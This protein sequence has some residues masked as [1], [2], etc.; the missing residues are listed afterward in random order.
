MS[1][2]P[3]T[4]DEPELLTAAAIEEKKK[5]RKHFGRFDIFFYLICTL[6]G[7][8][9]IGAAASKGAQGFTWLA[10]LGLF[11]FIP[12]GLLTA[13]LGSTFTDEGGPYTW[14]RMAFGRLVG[15][16]VSVL[17][18]LSNP[19][20]VGGTLCVTAVAAI[21]TFFFPAHAPMKEPVKYGISLFFIWGSVLAAVL[22]F[23]V[24]KWV[25]TVGAWARCGLLVFFT[26]SV[27]LY[28]VKN[29]VH[30][31]S[32]RDFRPTYDHFIALTPILLFNYFGFEL[33]S[34]AGDEMKNP[35]RDVPYTVARAAG[36]TLLLY[37]LPVLAVL[38]V[39]PAGQV[40]SL[41]GFL[42]AI[43]AVFTVYGGH[44]DAQGHA[45]LTGA[46]F[47]LGQAGAAAVVLALASSGTTWLMG[48]DRALAV[49]AYDGAGPRLLGRFSERWGTPVNANIL[50][51]ILSTIVMVLAFKLTHGDANKYFSAVLGLAISTNL[52]AYVAVFPALIRLRYTHADAKRFYRV[53]G[54]IGGAWAC[55]ALLTFWTVLATVALL[56]PGFGVGWFGTGGNPDEALPS[57]FAGQRWLYEQTQLIP[58]AGAFLIGFGFYALGTRTRQATVEQA[59]LPPQ[60]SGGTAGT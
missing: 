18:W 48:A 38:L 28:A 44:V 14:S 54:G 10:F 15:A 46:G 32:T 47:V 33:P 37:G 35:E 51:G 25:P 45:T 8:D 31:F 41:G 6:V 60:T 29:G 52:L 17:Y 1:T 12:Y 56:W 23:R 53:P 3:A 30:G 21:D 5:L 27:I 40:T 58:L 2:V 7:V 26:F 4:S 20:W 16:L 19:V 34:A 39:L 43:K 59:L 11:F 55:G 36:W 24:G 9:T 49:A 57:G 50:S 22:S 42:D 13:E